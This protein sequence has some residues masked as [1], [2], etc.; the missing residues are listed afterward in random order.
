MTMPG[1]AS[2]ITPK[3]EVMTA[4]NRQR[5]TESFLKLFREHDLPLKR[6]GEMIRDLW[7][8]H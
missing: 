5:D 2:S 3:E 8:R 4:I 7:G 6:L 1:I